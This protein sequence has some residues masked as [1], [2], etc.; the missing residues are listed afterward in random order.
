MNDGIICLVCLG[1]KPNALGVLKSS[2][3]LNLTFD[4]LLVY[5]WS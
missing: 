2:V 4:C 3:V 1:E 5:S